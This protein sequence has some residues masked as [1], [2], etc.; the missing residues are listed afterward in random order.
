[1]H[2][3]VVSQLTQC[4]CNVV[5]ILYFLF[6]IYDLISGPLSV[7]GQ[8]PKP[9]TP[10]AKEIPSIKFQTPLRRL[11]VGDLDL[12]LIWVLGFGI[13]SFHSYLSASIGSTL[14]ARRAGSQEANSATT[15]SK[16]GIATNVM[17]SVEPTPK[18]RLRM[19]R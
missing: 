18:S 5:S 17:G 3:L 7:A 1:T 8:I 16:T 6:T 11:P 14:D 12:G 19:S 9:Q 4:V 15:A 2:S 10:S 13:W